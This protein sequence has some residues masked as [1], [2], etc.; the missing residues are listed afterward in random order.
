MKYPS[1]IH[2]LF[3]LFIVLT[4]VNNCYT[5]IS[6]SVDGLYGKEKT[7]IALV[8]DKKKNDL[9]H[10]GGFAKTGSLTDFHYPTIDYD[11]NIVKNHGS[12]SS[13]TFPYGPLEHPSEGSA[14]F[15]SGKTRTM[16]WAIGTYLS[17]N[18]SLNRYDKDWFFIRFDLEHLRLSDNY[19]FL[20]SVTTWNGLDF[21]Q[22]FKRDQGIYNY[23]A[24]GFATRAGYKRILGKD[25]RFFAQLNLGV[26]Y[27]H[28]YYPEP[29]E[30]GQS[31]YWTGTP[32]MGVE[33]ETGIG[34]G[35]ILKK[36]KR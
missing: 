16:G 25:G 21:D 19:D 18:R 20:W 17:L 8:I 33:F 11:L 12:S 15:I 2:H 4:I 31:G 29:M 3:I 1:P 34:V 32:F 30:A 36:Y 9:V 23:H 24:I 22:E 5:Q 7:M 14:D 6:G 35:Y 10:F 28:P 13:Y 26:S 27:Y